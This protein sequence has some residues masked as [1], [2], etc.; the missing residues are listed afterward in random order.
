MGTVRGTAATTAATLA[1]NVKYRSVPSST[2]APTSR[3][4]GGSPTTS[5][6]RTASRASSWGGTSM[7]DMYGEK[8]TWWRRSWSVAHLI[9]N[10]A[11]CG[12]THVFPFTASVKLL[13]RPS[14]PSH[15]RP[16]MIRPIALW[17]GLTLAGLLRQPW[18]VL[19]IQPRCLIRVALPRNRLR[20]PRLVMGLFPLPS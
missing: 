3:P 6:L 18:A 13:S 7:R 15:L 11:Q 17:K 4:N 5:S 19:S 12:P 20:M 14:V 16:G 1:A 10:T 2:S 8:S 9:S